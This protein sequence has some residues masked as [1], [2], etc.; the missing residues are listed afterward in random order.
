MGG[1]I[2]PLNRYYWPYA[3]CPEPVPFQISQSRLE[4]GSIPIT[5]VSS[6]DC[7][8]RPFR[9]YIQAYPAI[10]A[11]NAIDADIFFIF[12]LIFMIYKCRALKLLD[13]NRAAVAIFGDFDGYVL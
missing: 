10:G 1:E 7:L 6:L 5:Q 2:I 4:P 8:Y 3:L 13:T 12:G 9:T 11:Q